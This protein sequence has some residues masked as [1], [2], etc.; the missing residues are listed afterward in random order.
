MFYICIIF[1]LIVEQICVW[2]WHHI[3]DMA[4]KE[5]SEGRCPA[6][7]TPY[8]KERIVGM[9]A[10]CERSQI[11]FLFPLPFFLTHIERI[12]F[13]Y[14]SL[15]LSCDRVVA[16]VNAEKRQKPQKSKPKTSADAR[17]HVSGVRVIQ[18]NLV[19]IIGLPSN[20]SDENVRDGFYVC[21]VFMIC[22]AHVLEIMHIY[23]IFKMYAASRAQ[24]VLWAVWE[25]PKG[26]NCSSD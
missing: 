19:Y 2:C 5:D 6:C 9:A 14:L 20:L 11:L 8:D 24:R 25:S 26:I 15:I 12:I 4:E 10:T 21:T 23:N 7:R 13:G 17:K 16:E 22:F 1:L 3:I 18:R